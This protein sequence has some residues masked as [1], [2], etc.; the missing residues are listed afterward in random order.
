[1]KDILGAFLQ[2]AEPSHDSMEK[3]LPYL[4]IKHS[5]DKINCLTLIE[6]IYNKQLNIDFFATWERLKRTDGTSNIDKFWF[7]KYTINELE[8]ELQYWKKINITESQEYDV[9]VFTS[10]KKVPI[11][12]GMYIHSNKFIHVIE[13]QYCRFSELDQEYRDKLRG[14]YRHEIMV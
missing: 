8:N 12:F 11:H 5:W 3:Y 9:L 1:M 13:E 10:L 4:K 2:P 6:D 7:R 14:V